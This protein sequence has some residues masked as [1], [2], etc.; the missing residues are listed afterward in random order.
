MLGLSVTTQDDRGLRNVWES[1]TRCM[2]ALGLGHRRFLYSYRS[3]TKDTQ[4]LLV[5]LATYTAFIHSNSPG[6]R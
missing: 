1:V 3:Y 4:K 5:C 2:G 6:L